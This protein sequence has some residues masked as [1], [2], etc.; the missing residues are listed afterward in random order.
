MKKL[1]IV[2]LLASVFIACDTIKESPC[3]NL[4]Q[5]GLFPK[6]GS[7]SIYAVA[8]SFAKE[9]GTLIHI[10]YR[11]GEW[12]VIRQNGNDCYYY[13]VEPFTLEKTLV[14]KEY[15]D[16]LPPPPEEGVNI[17]RFTKTEN[18]TALTYNSGK[19][20]MYYLVGCAEKRATY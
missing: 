11:K 16:S 4:T 10:R 7:K 13:N 8:K 20:Y 5:K 18:I 2:L 3:P 19:W 15:K 14:K 9:S 12:R 1:I 17:I 6:V